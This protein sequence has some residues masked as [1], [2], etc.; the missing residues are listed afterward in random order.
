[1]ATMMFDNGMRGMEEDAALQGSADM[2]APSAEETSRPASD[3]A[4][5]EVSTP[6]LGPSPE[7]GM[8]PRNPRRRLSNSTNNA[9][10]NVDSILQLMSE[11]RQVVILLDYDG[12]LTPIV[13]EPDR[14]LLPERNRRL[15]ER[16][17]LLYPT[18][19]VTGRSLPKILNFVRV[20]G[21]FY[22]GSH[23]F[24]IQAPEELATVE[25][26]RLR[27]RS[28][29]VDSRSPSNTDVEDNSSVGSSSCPPTRS[30]SH[31]NIY[32]S[33]EMAD[34]G[35]HV[36]HQVGVEAI[37]SLQL[38]RDAIA[39]AIDHL[40]LTGALVEDNIFSV[41]VHY[42]NCADEVVHVVEL[43]ARCAVHLHNSTPTL[44]ANVTLDA[45]VDRLVK[46][47]GEWRE[48][49]DADSAGLGFGLGWNLGTVAT[50]PLRISG[51]KKVWELRPD[52]QWDKGQAV[53]WVLRNLEDFRR[54]Q[55]A[56]LA[57]E[58]SNSDSDQSTK[59]DSSDYSE[60][61]TSLFTIYIGDDTTDE[62]A[63]AVFSD[64]DDEECEGSYLA[65]SRGAGSARDLDFSGM[66]IVVTEDA[67]DTKA[68]FTLRDPSQ[69]TEFLERLC[70]HA[71][72][73]PLGM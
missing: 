9:L 16:L 67:R 10:E 23:G 34:E 36:R 70:D 38:L 26:R 57:Q 32:Y 20:H 59:T 24:D 73:V 11:A 55:H 64:Q 3:T 61:Q 50:V 53:L 65:P 2:S 14:A 4:M 28:L 49:H 6:P 71:E 37:P 58:E 42:R 18:G 1:M 12:T 45:L 8:R 62:D 21:L 31:Q 19:V 48:K 52:I 54:R 30:N 56:M 72:T 43:L 39:H 40:G 66:G 13:N 46:L 51:G 33:P 44:H 63:F 47:V 17:T 7:S 69:V 25:R 27:Q 5:D 29:P 41:S 15:L 60:K 22:A 68:Q 35:S